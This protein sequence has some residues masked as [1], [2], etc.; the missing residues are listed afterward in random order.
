MSSTET[1][2]WFGPIRRAAAIARR[3]DNSMRDHQKIVNQLKTQA[4]ERWPSTEAIARH[5]RSANHHRRHAASIRF[6]IRAA[7]ES[8]YLMHEPG[9]SRRDP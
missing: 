9:Q 5:Q 8:P 1:L 7:I 2:N 3:N 6:A 4:S